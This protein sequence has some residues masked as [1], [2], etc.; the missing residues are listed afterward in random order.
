MSLDVYL[1]GE[2]VRDQCE[3]ECGHQHFRS[4]RPEL[5]AA[6]ITHNLGAMAK[7]AGLYEAVWRPEEIWLSKGSEV[8]ALLCGGIA[9]MEQ[10]PQKF[11]A[12]DSA[13]GWGTYRDFL[14]WLKT[15]LKACE[16]YPDA[17][18]KVSR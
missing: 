8:A 15:Y 17:E 14:P 1:Y 2:S 5:F 7:E 11:M 13:N 9:R 12:L 6:N 4:Y 18:V 3:C 16:E 10:D